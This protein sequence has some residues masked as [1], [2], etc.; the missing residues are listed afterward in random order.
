[1]TETMDKADYQAE[2]ERI[3]QSP[4]FARSPVLRRLLAY[5]I[6]ET[7]VGN[8]ARLKAYQIAVDGLGRDEDFDPQ[9]DS[10]PRVQV[11]RLRK[12]LDLFYADNGMAQVR[13]N[14]RLR[15]PNGA[16]CVYFDALGDNPVTDAAAKDNDA[17]EQDLVLLEAPSLSAASPANT[18]SRW[19]NIYWQSAGALL[20]IFGFAA[21]WIALVENSTAK[22][23]DINPLNLPRI[24]ISMHV[25][26]PL[27]NDISRVRQHFQIGLQRFERMIVVDQSNGHRRPVSGNARDYVLDV[28][29]A[30]T[31]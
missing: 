26:N 4:Q 30:G 28:S 11:G 15:I 10:Y 22:S 27:D 3:A 20:M 14:A 25:Q 13:P 31:R 18:R 8:G 1:M 7:L 23:Q 16:Y 9:S 29:A 2:F 19:P 24:A 12:M 21:I 17:D 6:E 5:L